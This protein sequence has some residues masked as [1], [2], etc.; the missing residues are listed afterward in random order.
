MYSQKVNSYEVDYSD[1]LAQQFTVDT[2]KYSQN[3]IKLRLGY[4]NRFF[5]ERITLNLSKNIKVSNVKYSFSGCV[6]P[7]K[8]K[9][10]IK[11]IY[12]V[13]NNEKPNKVHFYYTIKTKRIA[14]YL[15]REQK[16][17]WKEKGLL[18]NT[19]SF[20]KGYFEY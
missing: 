2:L 7:S 9:R 12:F 15:N 20:N 13:F 18:S 8:R 14:K 3:K 17:K 10:K 11:N 4:H 6:G 16:K 19:Y 1:S 5:G